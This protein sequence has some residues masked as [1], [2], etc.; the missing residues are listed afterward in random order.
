[1]TVCSSLA[2]NTMFTVTKAL[3]KA[4]HQ[5]FIYQK[6]EIAYAIHKPFPFF[7]ALRDNSFI[8][9]RMYS[10]SLEA[11]GNLVPISR[12]VYNILTKLEKTFDLSLLVTLFSQINLHEYPSLMAILR[13][14]K[15]VGASYEE[16]NKPTSIMFKAPDDPAEGSSHQTHL[17]L[18]SPHSCLSIVSGPKASSQQIDEI[19]EEQSSHS[20]PAVPL[21]G[22]IREGGS[23]PVTDDSLMSKTNEEEESREMP[24][25]PSDTVQEIREA[26]PIPCDPKEPPEVTSTPVNKKGKKRKRNIWSTPKKR[27][28]KKR[29]PREISHETSEMKEGKRPQKTPSTPRTTHGKEAALPGRGIQK[30]LQVV[31]QGTQ[32]NVVKRARNIKAACAKTSM[33]KGKPNNDTVDFLSPILPVTCGEAKGILYKEKMKQG[34]SEKCIQNEE[35][36]WLTINEF[37]VEGKRASS[38]CWKRSVRCGGQTLR[39]LIEEGLLLC[40]PKINLK[41]KVTSR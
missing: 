27:H 15:S 41:T 33:P 14:F 39:Q 28:Q 21:L 20:D 17:P 12:V 6:L 4:L 23:T 18:P 11:C 35:G 1:M 7:E 29:C 26:S 10:E 22:I 31:S 5:H 38:K 40:P 16:W 37:T 25:S 34:F 32:R 3:E 24:I 30:K 36:V 19:P 8:T 2:P 13:S 9:E